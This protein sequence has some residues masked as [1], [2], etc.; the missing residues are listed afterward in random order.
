MNRLLLILLAACSCISIHAQDSYYYYRGNKVPLEQDASKVVSISSVSGGVSL[1]PAGGFA[2]DKTITD[3]NYSI[4]VYKALPSASASEMPPAMSTS[5]ATG[6]VPCYKSKDAQELIPNGY[7]NI[8]LKTASDYRML[9]TMASQKKCTIIGR[10]EFMPLWYCLKTNASPGVNP[11]N[12]ANEMYET[13]KFAA[14]FPSFSIDALEISYDPDVYSQWGL[15][16]AEHE[17]YDISVCQAWDL[18]TGR[19]IKIAIVDHGIDMKHQDLAANIYPFSYDTETGTSPSKVYGK[20]ATHCAGIAAAIRNNGI[21]IAGVAPDAQLMSVSNT[22]F[23]TNGEKKLADGINWAWKNGADIISCSWWCAPNEL[24]GE[25]ID[26]AVTKGREG[27]GCVFVK[28][29]GN[30]RIDGIEAITFPGDY[31]KDVLAVSNMTKDGSLSTTSCHGENMFVA[32]PG[33]HILSTIPN[34]MVAYKSGTSMAC[35]HVAGVAA[36]VLERNPSLT[37]AK[38][39]EIIARNTKKIG[40]KAYSITKTYGSWNEYYGYGLVDAYNAVIHTPR[41]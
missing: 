7:I 23:G 15:Y 38:V 35:P 6:F 17:G 20:H 11:V 4:K 16:N 14:A 2:L 29:A 30:I 25:A 26:A 32:A 8:K 21:Q 12:V 24:I 36:L 9:E 40:T 10:N 34:N 3:E 33:T 28:S 27:K 19:G 31:S 37:A 13:G 22:L 41:Q 18:A 5:P 39:R 1:A